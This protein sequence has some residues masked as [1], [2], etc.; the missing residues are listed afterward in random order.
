MRKRI[1]SIFLAVAMIFCFLPLSAYADEHQHTFENKHGYDLSNLPDGY[2]IPCKIYESPCSDECGYS[3]YSWDVFGL[4]GQFVDKSG[5]SGLTVYQHYREWF[6]KIYGKNATAK[7]YQTGGGSA[8]TGGVGR[9]PSGYQ[10][11]TG[12]PSIN[13][14]GVYIFS[15]S[16]D[17]TYARIN[18]AS[19]TSSSTEDSKYSFPVYRYCADSTLKSTFDQGTITESGDSVKYSVKFDE[20]KYSGYFGERFKGVA[21][22][23]GQ[24]SLYIRPKY[25]IS[26]SVFSSSYNDSVFRSSSGN[27]G[28]Y[29]LD[30]YYVAG[31]T[32]S[33]YSD[34]S[35]NYI[36]GYYPKSV[37]YQ[38][39]GV[40]YL[41]CKP[42]A[43][44]YSK[45]TNITIYYKTYS[46]QKAQMQADY[47][48][49]AHG[50]DLKIGNR[51][52]YLAALEAYMLTGSSPE[53]AISKVGD[54]Y[55]IR[56]SKTT[57]Y[58]YIKMRLFPSLRYKHLPQGHPKKGKGQVH[59][60][61]VAHPGHRSIERRS[62]TIRTRKAPFHW[63][64]DSVV[65]RAEGKS[66]SCLVM[67]E[68]TTR[69]EIVLKVKDK[70]A[71]ETV[72]TLQRLKRE[73]GRDW[74]MIF[75][76]L[77]CDNGPEFAD[78]AGIDALGV[79]TFYCH[80]QAPHERGTNEVTNK[81]V[82]RKLPKGKSMAKVT[83]KQATEVQHWVNHYTRPMFG[84][85]SAA[86]KLRAE[87]DKLSLY[88]R[89]KVYKFF[90]L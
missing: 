67:T 9:H 84:G 36:G 85:K 41:K 21:P 87:L 3:L 44:L 23:D 34:V 46:P 13:L 70:T 16:H 47:M 75:K 40:P 56:I 5:T 26:G 60:S 24:Y 38:F 82:R 30:S 73:I 20:Y 43:P 32:I 69:A 12:T 4:S 27:L 29:G 86:D 10:D 51:R 42:T 71:A 52:D 35:L 33:I 48:K 53:D 15:L 7:Q 55:G 88:N 79:T 45:K 66:E 77:T 80:P 89:A 63:E 17:Y 39:T 49:T 14:D 78:Q 54:D 68:R 76:T 2:S 31:S 19:K 25:S 37:T 58:R 57:C 50:P 62:H 8:G 65:G 18:A 72:K 11:S 64:I 74:Y 28:L 6:E 59:R 1:F 90:D 22:C 81:L 83:Q 61:N